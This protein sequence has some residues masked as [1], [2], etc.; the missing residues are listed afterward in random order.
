MTV[1][2]FYDNVFFIRMHKISEYLSL[3]I[4]ILTSS[5]SVL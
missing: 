3:S 1:Y 5:I 4:K 2:V